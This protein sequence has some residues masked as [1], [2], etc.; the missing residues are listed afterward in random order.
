MR[1]ERAYS[2]ASQR[3]SQLQ[4]Q[5]SDQQLLAIS[6]DDDDD[7]QEHPV[8]VSSHFVIIGGGLAEW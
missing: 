4:Q 7:Q 6:D 1:M 3:I 2:E 5:L 8:N